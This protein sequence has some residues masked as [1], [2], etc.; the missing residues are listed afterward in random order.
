METQKGSP[1]KKVRY[2]I[3][4]PPEATHNPFADI[5]HFGNEL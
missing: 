3:K 5:A 4:V 2:W 1:L